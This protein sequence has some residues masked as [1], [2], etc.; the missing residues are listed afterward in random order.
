[1]SGPDWEE[2]DVPHLL[3]ALAW[4][5]LVLGD[6]AA[7]AALATE[8]VERMR[9]TGLPHSLHDPGGPI[10]LVDALRVQALVTLRQGQAAEAQALLE[11]ASGIAR[12]IPYPYGEARLLQ[13]Y[14][15][16]HAAQGA[17]G[18]ARAHLEAALIILRRL[19]AHVEIERTEKLLFTLG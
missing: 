3:P 1:L 5:H 7:A 12:G 9:A 17:P 19:G 11:E 4:A 8:A 2:V 16:F 13:V 18:P 10:A 6:V 14:G 15:Q